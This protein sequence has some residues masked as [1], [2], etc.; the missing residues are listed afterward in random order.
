[1]DS[2][3]TTATTSTTSTPTETIYFYKVEDPYNE[4]SNFAPYPIEVDGFVYPTNEH[5]FQASKF[6][7]EKL[8]HTIR[9]CDS[10][11]RAFR[12]G[13]N[14]GYKDKI[15]S[16]WQTYR[17]EVMR[18]AIYAKFTQHDSLKQLLLGTGDVLIV[19]DSPVDSFWG[20]GKDRDG[21]NHLGLLLVELRQK[22]REEGSTN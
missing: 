20:C 5:Y 6:N 16:D 17:L 21:Q 8:H 14:P 15:R 2:A 19:E 9:E 4:F 22:L 7:D 18:K 1:M 12:Y 13:R 10:P 3:P 11:G